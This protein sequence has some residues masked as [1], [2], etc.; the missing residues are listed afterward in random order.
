MSF[1]LFIPLQSTNSVLQVIIHLKNLQSIEHL[2]FILLSEILELVSFNSNIDQID[3]MSPFFLAFH[4]IYFVSIYDSLY[5][6]IYSYMY[7]FIKYSL[8]Q[9]PVLK[10][11]GPHYL[12]FIRTLKRK[13]AAIVQLQNTSM[14]LK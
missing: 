10:L 8:F 7:M 9:N 14:K 13:M 3:F 12:L 6:Y 4:Y 1:Q 2:S 5:L 11:Q